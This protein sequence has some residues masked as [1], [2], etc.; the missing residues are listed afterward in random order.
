MGMTS[1][2]QAS[3]LIQPGVIASSAERPASPFEGQCIFQKDTDQLLV[4]NGTAWVIPNA[5]AQNPTGLEIVSPSTVS[6]GSG[7]YSVSTSGAVTFTNVSSVSLNSVFNTIYENYKVYVTFTS[8]HSADCEMRLRMRTGTTDVQGANYIYSAIISYSGSAILTSYN[9][10]SGQTAFRLGDQTAG[11]YNKL[12]IEFDVLSPV[13]STIRTSMR[14]NIAV[15]VNPQ[16]Y[17]FAVRG[18]LHSL[19]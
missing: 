4:W 11:G 14:A 8:A 16:P 17:F 7:S 13:T 3:R 12:P 15:P 5:P 18:F 10:G 2:S 19:V 6:V 9:A 1:Q